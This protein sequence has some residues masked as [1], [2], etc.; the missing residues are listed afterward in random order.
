MYDVDLYMHMVEGHICFGLPLHFLG[1][2][3][4]ATVSTGISRLQMDTDGHGWIGQVW[5]VQEK[6]RAFSG[7]D[8]RQ[9]RFDWILS[10]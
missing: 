1:G 3:L 7:L 2:L 6:S 10:G 5:G 8:W 9:W 4:I